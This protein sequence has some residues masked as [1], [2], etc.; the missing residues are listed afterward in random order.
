[1]LADTRNTPAPPP[2]GILSTLQRHPIPIQAR[3]EHCLALAYAVPAGALR[4]FLVPGLQLDTWK[5][6]GMLALAL[7]QTRALRPAG[8]PA[9]CGRDFFLAGYRVFVRYPRPGGS[10]L[11]GLRILRSDADSAVMV[12]GGNV[13]THYNYH[14]CR[15]HTSILST[16]TGRSME[17]TV[18]TGDGGGDLH[19]VAH[20]DEP[21]LP[22]GSPFATLREARRFAGPMPFTFDYEAETG[23]LV[24][25]RASRTNWTPRPVRVDAH[26]VAFLDRLARGRFTPV[27]AAAFHVQ[28]VNYR[29]ERGVVHPVAAG[30]EALR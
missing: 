20:L 8:L 30:E 10:A 11:R 26:R 21:G 6:Y 25:I 19:L 12:A 17:V 28:N 5:G 29:W 2:A 9:W 22:T 3:F 4:P 16:A 1:M 15:A 27:L 13:F 7:V 18:G 24:A 23:A 14:R